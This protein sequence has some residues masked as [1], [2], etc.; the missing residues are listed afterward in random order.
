MGN[1]AEE[2]AK[3]LSNE[4]SDAIGVNCGTLDPFEVSQ[5][6]ARFRDNTDLPLIAQPNAGKPKL[7]NGK[8][9][10]DLGP[11]E[12][13]RGLLECVKHGARFVGGCCGTG[14]VHIKAAAEILETIPEQSK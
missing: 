9:V 4:G 13:A 5:V 7:E 3:V 10:F 2:C 11:E 14:P 12:F 8:T 1:S 6:I